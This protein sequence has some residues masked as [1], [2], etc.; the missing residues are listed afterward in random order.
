[1]LQEEQ[2]SFQEGVLVLPSLR[3]QVHSS[4]S[5]REMRSQVFLQEDLPCISV[6]RQQ[7]SLVRMQ[8][9]TLTCIPLYFL[10]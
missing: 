6:Q 4:P 3:P 5:L 8:M 9:L 2:F 10:Y 7:W 1:M